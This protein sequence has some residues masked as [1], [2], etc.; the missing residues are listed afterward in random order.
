M[1]DNQTDVISKARRQV[2]LLR[3]YLSHARRALTRVNQY[4]RW[5]KERE[6]LATG[7]AGDYQK[8]ATHGDLPTISLLVPVYNPPVA[9]LRECLESVIAQVYPHWQLCIADDASTDSQVRDCLLEFSKRDPRIKVVFREENGHI[10]KASNTALELVAGDY[11][12]L[13]DHDDLLAPHALLRVAQQVVANPELLLVYSDEDKIDARGKRSNPHFKPDWNP[14]LLLG[15]NYIC[16]LTVFRTQLIRS[17]GG[18]REGTE[19]S[20]DHDLLLRCMP[21]LSNRNVT[22]I[23]DVLY[24]WRTI[25]G[26]TAASPSGKDYTHNA[27][28]RAVSDYLVAHHPGAQVV[29]GP[30]SNSYRTKWPL[31]DPL[32]KVSLLIPTRDG[33]NILK[34]C[35]DAILKNT[36]YTAL[37]VLILDNQ[38]TCPRTLAYFDEL[39]VDDRVAIHRWDHPFNFSAINNFG[40]KMA[41]GDIIGLVNNDIEPINADWL[42]EMVS[43]AVRPDIGCVGAKLYYPNGAIQHAGVILGIG[44]VAGHS[45]KY[46]SPNSY[47]YFL[48]LKLVQ[49]LSAVTG[50]CLLVRKSVFDEVGGLDEEHLAIAFND[51]D[52]C[53]KVREAGYRNI[54]TP[55]AELYH[56]ESASR[57][58]EDTEKNRERFLRETRV[59]RDRWGKVLDLDPAY[60]PNLTRRREDFS[61]EL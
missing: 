21:Y 45:H 15:L 16:H 11:V 28:L 47:G 13:L 29:E 33:V 35:V 26:S 19:G 5:I 56:H 55:Y 38:T 48:R 42:R 60:N 7:F 25:K 57:G 2:T 53:L 52:F 27:G 9:L 32:P 22:R 36:D 20:Q 44:G 40:A 8:L 1:N 18:F 46:F 14:D 17:V 23:P 31:P 12:G 3:R 54:W 61:L 34:P 58:P 37:E 24:H 49:N 6:K 51:V 41:T 10:V 59:M 4:K 39:A 43:H 50:A 30:L